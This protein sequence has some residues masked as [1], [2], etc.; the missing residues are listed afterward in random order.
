VTDFTQGRSFVKICGITTLDDARMVAETGADAIGLIFAES[1]RQL[2]LEQAALISRAVEGLIVRVGVFRHHASDFVVRAVDET[3]VDVAQI[4]GDLDGELVDALRS[5][6][7]GIIKALSVNAS[8]YSD[9]DERNVD[10]VLLDGPSPGSGL[11]HAWP[12]LT[13]RAFARHVI[14]AGG[15]TPLN[16]TAVLEATGAWGVDVSSGVES[17]PGQ[18]DP[19]RVSDFVTNARAFFERGALRG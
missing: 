12:D 8:E 11:A 15:L 16:V 1:T 17:A 4:H 19:S 5:R 18:K 2:S 7:V 13:V 9:F 10:A 6:G 3:G 14:A